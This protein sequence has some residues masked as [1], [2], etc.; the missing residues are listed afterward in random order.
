MLTIY[1]KKIIAIIHN[2]NRPLV[3]KL[4]TLN[5]FILPNL[6][7]I[8]FKP[9]T[10]PGGN[11]TCQQV[12]LI[13]GKGKVAFGKNCT[14]GFKLG[15]FH[16]GGC[17]EFQSRYEMSQIKIGHNVATNNNLFFCAANYI[18]IGDDCLVGQ[19]VTIMD[20]DAHGVLPGARRKTPGTIGIVKIGRNVWICNNVTILKNTIIG[21][22]S[23][24]AAGAVVSGKFP[25]DVIIGGIP[26]KV[27][28]KIE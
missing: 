22:N 27:I 17:I 16:R 23:I 19:Y 18:E 14:F 3:S 20:H 9:A 8:L 4:L 11:P 6:F 28:K 24:V 7:S 5:N 26:A 12:T 13:T 1:L 2:F 25:S 15:G 21:D 10:F